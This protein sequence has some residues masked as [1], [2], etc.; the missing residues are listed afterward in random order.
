MKKNLV[1]THKFLLTEPQPGLQVHASTVTTTCEGDPLVGWFVGPHEGHPSTTI[2]V[3]RGKNPPTFPCLNHTEAQWNP[4]LMR[5]EDQSL[6]L[7]YKQGN[8][9]E[10]WKTW[11]VVSHDDGRTWS[12]PRE[13]V[14]ADESGGRG[15]IRQSPIIKDR[16]WIAAGSVENWTAARWDCFVDISDDRGHTWQQHMIPLDHSVL[17]GAGCIQPTITPGRE[18][19][20]VM[21]ARSTQGHVFRSTS[22][23][24]C[25]WSPLIPTSLP[26]NNSGIAALADSQGTLWCAHNL[27]TSNWGARSTLAMSSS[28]D[29]GETWTTELIIEKHASG[30]T[31]RPRSV[32][33]HGVITDGVGEY[34]YPAMLCV[35]NELWVTYSWQRQAIALAR[36]SMET[37]PEA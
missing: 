18:H 36:L 15:P 20:F 31:G 25:H 19:A 29:D 9:I 5:V 4:V 16:R 7:F 35:G 14:P 11:V 26:N 12:E 2:A 28:D 13:L 1:L 32:S 27:S 17:D 8:S 33:E 22:D 23:D 37:S 34:S 3:K 24:G 30:S 10:R 6:W 21:L